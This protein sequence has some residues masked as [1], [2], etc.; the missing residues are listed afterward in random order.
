MTEQP[1]TRRFPDF[2]GVTLADILANGA[3]I[4][5]L[6]IVITVMIK[7]E[8]ERKR[9]EQVEEV[10]VLLSRDLA[11]SVVMNSLPTSAPATLHNYVTSPLDRNPVHEIMPILEFHTN[12]V[13]NFYT[14]QRFTREQLL[15]HDNP[16]DLYLKSLGP[17][18]IA[19]LRADIYSIN[20]FYLSMSIIED[21]LPGGPRHWHFLGYG[22]G[23]GANESSGFSDGNAL[24]DGGL[25]DGNG[26]DGLEGEGNEEGSGS[27]FGIGGNS[28]L[29][30]PSLDLAPP[31]WDGYPYDDLA[32]GQIGDGQGQP[33]QP[34]QPGGQPGSSQNPAD[35]NQD[36]TPGGQS[37]DG[38]PQSSRFRSAY[39]VREEATP[40]GGLDGSISMYMVLRGLFAFMEQAQ[41]DADGGDASVLARYNFATDV[42]PLA[43]GILAEEDQPDP[44]T[45]SFFERLAVE[46]ESAPWFDERP[47]ESSQKTDDNMPRQVLEVAIN[48]PI[49]E[50]TL[51]GDSEQ[52]QLTNMPEYPEIAA[53]LGLYPSIFR[54]VRVPVNES[55][56]VLMPPAQDDP[57][58][59]RWRVVTVV[60]SERND[61]VT[62]FVYSTLGADGKLLIAV[63]EN[64]VSLAGYRLTTKRPTVPYRDQ[65]WLLLLYALPALLLALGIFRR[66]FRTR[67]P[68]PVA[69]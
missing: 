27:Q 34:G 51:I 60:N 69:G 25:S 16:L 48:Q 31:S 68:Q 5:I 24:R 67:S 18:Q 15:Y 12:Y 40:L 39:E 56:I 47:P 55:S 32:P 22:Q 43:L 30:D 59:F 53:H 1:A 54:G 52:E 17:V 11:T 63:E 20:L 46:V 23:G 33:G 4:L 36:G 35:A 42:L 3:A 28:L 6:M 64:A 19:R 57:G 13:R 7:H 37:G 62:A 29:P 45:H 10:S 50:A 66:P 41:Q 58:Q 61:F 14:G 21:Y 65:R 8:E 26:E 49:V 9:L 44:E 2:A 38:E